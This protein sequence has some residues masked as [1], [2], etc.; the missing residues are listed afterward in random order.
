MRHYLRLL[1]NNNQT[2]QDTSSKCSARDFFY[3]LL[4]LLV[5]TRGK[6]TESFITAS[7]LKVS[8][9][10]SG[11][12]SYGIELS[13]PPCH[14]CERYRSLLLTGVCV[15]TTEDFCKLCNVWRNFGVNLS[16]HKRN[17]KIALATF[18]HL[19]TRWR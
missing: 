7:A 1:E 5:F 15:S 13:L 3:I 2:F 16:F 12:H 11:R 19:G 8:V 17:S 6:D 10:A 4:T 18:H 9:P 14:H